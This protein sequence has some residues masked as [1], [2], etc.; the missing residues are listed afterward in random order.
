ML[1]E[2]IVCMSAL[3]CIFNLFF[4]TLQVN[5]LL[6]VAQKYQ[7]AVNEDVSNVVSHQDQQA[8]CNMYVI[9]F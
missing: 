5:Q 7:A 8:I 9:K 1:F 2:N 4:F 3:V 6:Q